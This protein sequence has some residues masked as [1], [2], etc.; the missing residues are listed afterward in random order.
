[1]DLIK[2]RLMLWQSLHPSSVI[3]G[4]E[5]HI[6]NGYPSNHTYKI[7]QGKLLPDRQLARRYRTI[8]G[9][10]PVELTSLAEISCSK[11]FFVFSASHIPACTRT[12]GIDINQYDLDVCRWVKEKIN[13][14]AI[15]KNIRLHELAERIDEFGGPF[16]TVLVINTYQ[17]LYFGS[18]Y[19]P[20]AYLDH[21]L[22]FKSLRKICKGRVIFNNR[23]QLS[24]CQNVD[25]IKDASHH[26]EHYNESK[27][28]EV[29]SQYFTLSDH[30]KIGKYPLL[31]FD[32]E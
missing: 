11:G 1:M 6:K 22:I 12:L 28:R 3:Q 26:S 32:V 15:F 4:Y 20:E 2:K 19:F 24:D 25:Q 30:G 14:R 8:Y 17:Y 27:V 10:Y 18:I 7:K 21:D 16:Q 13:S 23:I 9:L 5:N 29:A 31:T